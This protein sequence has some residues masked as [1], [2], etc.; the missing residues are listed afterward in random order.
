MR[1][2]AGAWYRMK[3]K[4]KEMGRSLFRS[5]VARSGEAESRIGLVVDDA[6]L[7]VAVVVAVATVDHAVAVLLLDAEHAVRSGK[8]MKKKKEKRKEK[9]VS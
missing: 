6:E 2:P 3:K 4:T 7:S 9:R 1:S 8:K 5:E